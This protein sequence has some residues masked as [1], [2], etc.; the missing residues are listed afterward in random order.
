MASL[1]HHFYLLTLP[2]VL[3]SISLLL[4]PVTCDEKECLLKGINSFRQSQNLSMLK[5]N[6]KASCFARQIAKQLEGQACSHVTDPNTVPGVPEILRKC[7]VKINYTTEG[8]MLSV[9]V[10]NRVPNLVLNNFTRKFYTMYLKNSN[11][12]GAGIGTEDDWTVIVL[13]TSTL[14]GSFSSFACRVSWSFYYLILILV[15]V[16]VLLQ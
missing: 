7:K 5:S 14:A 15:L 11:F 16:L 10:E 3:A 1:N 12:T 2:L 4:T 13:S 6:Q 9:C 8:L